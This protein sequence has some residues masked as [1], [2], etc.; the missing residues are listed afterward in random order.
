MTGEDQERFEDYL[1][2]EHYIEEIRAGRVA[3]P[4]THL[5]PDQA[6]IYRM[7]ALFRS[8]TPGAA[9]PRPEFAE[10]L[11]TRLLNQNDESLEEAD[12]LKL[13]PLEV[14]DTLEVP[15]AET[16]ITSEKRPE[17]SPASTLPKQPKPRRVT[18]FSRRALL[19]GGQ[20]PLPR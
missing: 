15:Q 14:A 17:V 8:A 3:H 6:R 12:T 2:L 18:F 5:T 10:A 19:T 4:P 20:L 7:V 11:R 9:E 1:E 13:P 16:H